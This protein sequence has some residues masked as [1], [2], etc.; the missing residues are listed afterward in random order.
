MGIAPSKHNV[1]PLQAKAM[2]DK[3][4]DAS[5]KRRTIL[6]AALGVGGGACMVSRKLSAEGIDEST[7]PRVEPQ[8]V[9]AKEGVAQ[10]PGARLW[11]WDTGGKGEA[12]I[13]LH[14]GTGSGLIWGYQ[15]PVFAQA[16]YRV[17]GYSRRGYYGSD[18]QRGSVGDDIDDLA[19]LTTYL[20]LD[21]FHLVGSAG[22]A[23]TVPRFAL[24][25]PKRVLSLT[26]A[27]S[28]MG[29]Q[30]AEYQAIEN[31]LTPQGVNLPPEFRELSPSY[32]A[33]NHT[34][35][36]RWLALNSMS[37][38]QPTTS[39]PTSSTTR[40]S[41]NGDS[42]RAILTWQQLGALP[43]PSMVLVGDADLLA[44]A[45]VM[46]TYFSK[47]MPRAELHVITECGHSP[48][49]E[50]PEIFNR[51]VLDFIRRHPRA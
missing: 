34:G 14:P 39:P 22:G 11:Y 4:I 2:M 31:V 42:A 44:P 28:L 51:L 10:L 25:Y 19:N 7:A 1:L 16:G 27:C 24:A 36:A 38:A 32:R 5:I 8:Q 50:Q 46:R 47:Y 17:I 13:F 26:M 6:V 43:A 29:V 9:A 41:V 45:S 33:M 23:G 48:Y 15:Q 20:G 30:D 37:K 3:R 12:V 21:R 49:W 18:A 35:V 40:P